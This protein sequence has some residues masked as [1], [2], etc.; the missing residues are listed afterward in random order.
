MIPSLTTIRQPTAQMG[1]LAVNT[2]ID[3]IQ[4]PSSHKLHVILPVELVIRHSCGTLQVS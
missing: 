4:N 1:T 2:L 3:L